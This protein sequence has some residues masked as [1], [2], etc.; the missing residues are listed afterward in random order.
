MTKSAGNTRPQGLHLRRIKGSNNDDIW[1]SGDGT[2]LHWE[3]RTGL[4]PG[5]PGFRNMFSGIVSAESG[6][7]GVCRQQ[8]HG[9]SADQR[10]LSCVESMAA[11]SARGMGPKRHG[12]LGGRWSRHART[13]AERHTTSPTVGSVEPWAISGTSA[14]NIWAVGDGSTVLHY[15]GN[16]LEPV[17]PCASIPTTLS[18]AASMQIP[19]ARSDRWRRRHKPLA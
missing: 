10:H 5:G 11:R 3:G 19:K 2:I 13:G 6:L 12:F 18:C 8:W 16:K 7:S 15:D 17:S 1:A 9:Q 4:H 14:S